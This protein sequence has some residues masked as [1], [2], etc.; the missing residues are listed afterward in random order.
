MTNPIEERLT[1]LEVKA[2][3]AEDLL[4]KLDQ[5][6]IHQQDQIDRLER[7]VQWLRQQT[8]PEDMAASRNLRDEL[9]PHY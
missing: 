3:F 5:I 7:E 8:P 6:I 4:D 2:S 9:P 1:N